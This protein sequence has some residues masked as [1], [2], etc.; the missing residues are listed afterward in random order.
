MT[1]IHHC[2]RRHTGAFTF[3]VLVSLSAV[4]KTVIVLWELG[5]RIPRCGEGRDRVDDRRILGIEEGRGGRKLTIHADG[6]E[7]S[8]LHAQGIVSDLASELVSWYLSPCH[9]RCP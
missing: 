3:N 4:A 8:A 7:I 5:D 9:S 6:G 2:Q 1:G